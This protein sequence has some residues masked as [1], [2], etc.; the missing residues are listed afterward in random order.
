MKIRK[1]FNKRKMVI[2][3]LAG[4][5]LFILIPNILADDDE[6]ND[7]RI[8]SKKNLIAIHDSSSEKYKKKCSECHADIPKAQSLDPSIPAAHESMFDFAPGKPGDDKQCRWCHLTVDL[9]Q[10]SAGNL[11]KQIDA[12]LCT[13]CHGPLDGNGSSAAVQFYKTRPSPGPS[14]IEIGGERLYELV[15]SACHKD[16]ADSSL[17]GK[18][19]EKIVKAIEKNKGE[20]GPLSKLSP[21]DI[22]EIAAALAELGGDDD[23]D[24]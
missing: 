13:L 19:A 17:K 23:D 12:T 24:D 15:C 1:I 14:P 20:M 10:G 8:D 11:R 7:D 22:N 6:K 18:P 21:E 5:S 2:G 3:L 16:L 9:V 4:V